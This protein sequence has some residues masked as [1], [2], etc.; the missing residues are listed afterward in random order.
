MIIVEYA[1]KHKVNRLAQTLGLDELFDPQA[2]AYLPSE[3]YFVSS[4]LPFVSSGTDYALEVNGNA[5]TEYVIE[6]DGNKQHVAMFPVSGTGVW[7]LGGNTINFYIDG[8]LFDTKEV[9]TKN[10]YALL[11]WN[12]GLIDNALTDIRPPLEWVSLQTMPEEISS[13]KFSSLL[14]QYSY[15]PES[16]YGPLVRQLFTGSTNAGTVMGLAQALNGC[17]VP[18]EKNILMVR[19]SGT[20]FY[21]LIVDPNDIMYRRIEFFKGVRVFQELNEII[22]RSSSSSLD[23]ITNYGLSIRY[24]AI[25][26]EQP[27]IVSFGSEIY[28]YDTD[29]VIGKDAYGLA[30]VEWQSGGN[31]PPTGASYDIT[32]TYDYTMGEEYAIRENTDGIAYIDWSKNVFSP[33]DGSVYGIRLYYRGYD[34]LINSLLSTYRWWILQ[35]RRLHE[36]V[37]KTGD[38]YSYTLVSSGSYPVFEEQ[39]KTHYVVKPNGT[40]TDTLLRDT[41][42]TYD[43][44]AQDHKI[45][46]TDWLNEV[47]TVTY[48]GTVYN[49]PYDYVVTS[50]GEYAVID[51]AGG[52]SSPPA[53]GTYSVE[54]SLAYS[55]GIRRK[56]LQL[57]KSRTRSDGIIVKWFDYVFKWT[58]SFKVR[59]VPHVSELVLGPIIDGYTIESMAYP[60]VYYLGSGGTR[61]YISN[62]A[63]GSDGKTV[64]IQ[65]SSAIGRTVYIEYYFVPLS[66][67]KYVEER[68]AQAV[69][70]IIN[71]FYDSNGNLFKL[72][73]V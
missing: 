56:W 3:T 14:P 46:K 67:I 21:D 20:T 23:Y 63:I 24:S 32:F 62:Y 9:E 11:S 37:D 22:I 34:L 26:F 31:A 27:I 41:A 45:V 73:G 35:N 17:V 72:L 50:V 40:R 65:D 48:S 59:S 6:L 25:N 54:Y 8:N 47:K 12:V 70:N 28:S 36:A 60:I 43:Y 64:T 49:E 30:Y 4:T 53:S 55:T 7:K 16:A 38:G 18:E 69:S 52:A 33:I 39:N 61:V 1:G 15:L 58:E 51:W 57:L 10:I 44:L 19:A 2:I 13:I 42:L 66:L 29:Y 68:A 71:M 5:F